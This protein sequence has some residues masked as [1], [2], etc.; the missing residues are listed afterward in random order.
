MEK[1]VDLSSGSTNLTAV[2]DQYLAQDTWVV[3]FSGGLDSSVLL[4][5]A[6]CA[7][8]AYRLKLRQSA[9]PMA[10]PNLIACHVNHQLSENSDQWA[11]HCLAF[12]KALDVPLTT[13]VVSIRERGHGIESAARDARY[14]AFRQVM[15]EQGGVLFTAHHSDDQAETLLLKLARGEGI[16]GLRG[17]HKNRPFGQ[18]LIARPLLSQSRQALATYAAQ[19]DLQWVE[20]ESNQN[21]DFDRNFLRHE[22]MPLLAERW[23]AYARRSTIAAQHA[24]EHCALLD[25]VAKEDL[26]LCIVPESLFGECLDLELLLAMSLARRKNCLLK[27]FES[28]D[29]FALNIEQWRQ[30]EHSIQQSSSTHRPAQLILQRSGSSNKNIAKRFNV[31]DGMLYAVADHWQDSDLPSWTDQLQSEWKKTQAQL[32]TQ[33]H[34]LPHRIVISLAPVGELSFT[35]CSARY[36]QSH[37][38]DGQDTFAIAAPTALSA[39]TLASSNLRISPAA[40]LKSLSIRG[41]NQRLKNLFQQHRVPY[42]LRDH[43]PVLSMKENAL[44]VPGI[45]VADRDNLDIVS[46]S[47]DSAIAT[48]SGGDVMYSFA[49]RYF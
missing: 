24:E 34:E 29:I 7:L 41:V 43:Y 28:F 4:H 46:T 47:G 48:K 42:W 37:A 8:D 44:A 11:S 33:Q 31:Y 18:G 26:A 25:E 15:P 13:Q 10:V 12:C 14:A 23:P 17:I 3:A 27:W 2:F 9:S 20:D 32:M 16:K 49:W 36:Q 45:A 1:S 5:A 39:A 38:D 22:V 30:L 6:K 35:K 40:T 19:Q 21:R